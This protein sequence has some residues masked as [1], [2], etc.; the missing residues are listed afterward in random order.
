MLSK[1]AMFFKKYRLMIIVV[2]ALEAE[3]A[4][5]YFP[6]QT[7]EPVSLIGIGS[8]N[9]QEKPQPY[10]DVLTDAK[11]ELWVWLGDNVYCDTEDMARMRNIY[12]SQF[13]HVRY[14]RFRETV[15]IIGVWDDHDYGENNSGRWYPKKRESQQLLLDF[16]EEPDDS[17]RR[18]REGVFT[19]HTFG[20]KGKQLKFILLDNRYFADI[21][22]PESDILGESQWEF[23]RSELQ[24]STAQ[25]IFICSGTQI[26]AFDQTFEN[27]GNFPRSRQ[28]LLDLIRASQK[29]GI[30]LLSGD[31]HFHEISI[32]ND[33]TVHYPLIDFTSS[34]MNISATRLKAEKNRYRIGSFYKDLGF[35]FIVI[36]WEKE[37]PTISLQV[38]DH[39]NKI[40]RK[41]DISLSSLQPNKDLDDEWLIE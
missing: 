37:D 19:S 35:G 29:G 20:P 5:A 8:C 25:L 6:Y 15:P 16:L 39:K 30:I 27:W 32:V 24:A 11:V 1:L 7:A 9:D 22:G 36:D 28:R 31:R 26:L 23:L 17:P 21:P 40:R 2:L 13:N 12:A 10:W 3:S 33:E 41:F 18:T 34:G 38:R 4:S 14:A